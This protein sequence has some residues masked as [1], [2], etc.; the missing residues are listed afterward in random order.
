MALR[1]RHLNRIRNAP[2]VAHNMMHTL[3]KTFRKLDRRRLDR[4]G[5]QIVS[6]IFVL[7]RT[8]TDTVT[9]RNNKE[10][11]VIHLTA[12]HRTEEVSQAQERLDVLARERESVQHFRVIRRIIDKNVVAGRLCREEPVHRMCLD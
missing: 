6:V 3:C 1:H 7:F 8:F 4:M 2:N 12:L 9:R 5:E 10:A 11:D